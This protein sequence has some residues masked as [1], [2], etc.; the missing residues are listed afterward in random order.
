M[1]AEQYKPKPEA[2][3]PRK[4]LQNT[5]DLKLLKPQWSR[6][7]ETPQSQEPDAKGLGFRGLGFRTNAWEREREREREREGLGHKNPKTLHS[8]PPES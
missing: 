2:G 5:S 4:P 7:F 1:R 8:K 6:K 3:R